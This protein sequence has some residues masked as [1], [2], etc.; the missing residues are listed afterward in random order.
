[1]TQSLCCWKAKWVT[2]TDLCKSSQD[3]LGQLP[4]PGQEWEWEVLDLGT[5]ETAPGLTDSSTTAPLGMVG[6]THS[7]Q[8]CG[9]HF[10]LNL[11][12]NASA[13]SWK[14]FGGNPEPWRGEEQLQQ[15]PAPWEL[16]GMPGSLAAAK[17]QQPWTVPV[18]CRVLPRQPRKPLH[19][20]ENSETNTQ[21]QTLAIVRQGQAQ[22]GGNKYLFP[23][24]QIGS[25]TEW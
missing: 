10:R 23:W 6:K 16:Q 11:C 25:M 4:W 22:G 19:I 17:G 7:S 13:T 2:L 8:M 21:T 14:G 9:C 18:D 20:L 12:W 3:G 24:H 5:G 15:H 1:M